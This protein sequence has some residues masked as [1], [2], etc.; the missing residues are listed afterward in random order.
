MLLFKR[1]SRKKK[2]CQNTSVKLK[3]Q[4]NS[5]RVT[6]KVLG[7]ILVQGYKSQNNCCVGRVGAT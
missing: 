5:S 7:H 3:H 2:S 4:E 1:E 6:I